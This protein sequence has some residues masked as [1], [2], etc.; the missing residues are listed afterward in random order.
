M[1]INFPPNRKLTRERTRANVEI[2]N[3][4]F[5]F[6][7]ENPDQRFGQALIN[8]GII[9]K[10]VDLY[11]IESKSVLKSVKCTVKKLKGVKK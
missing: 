1:S 8:L 5:A 4:L 10:D 7:I 6:L 11:G 2:I 3:I 9:Q